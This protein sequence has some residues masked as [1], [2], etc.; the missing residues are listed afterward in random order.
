MLEVR[1][2]TGDRVQRAGCA[3]LTMVAATGC[4]QIFGIDDTERAAD[5]AHVIDAR[6]DGTRPDADKRPDA[7]HLPRGDERDLV[8]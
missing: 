6:D 8:G 3:I 5:A 2:P 7:A 4:R 1:G